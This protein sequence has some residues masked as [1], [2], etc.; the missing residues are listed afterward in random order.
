MADTDT[1]LIH[2]VTDGGI[3]G[4]HPEDEPVTVLA[5]PSPGKEFN[6]VKAFLTPTGC[7]RVEDLL[8]EF[9]SS[10]VR[11]NAREELPTLFQLMEDHSFKDLDS[12][13]TRSPVLSIF[14]HADPTGKDDYNKA[15][16]GR[17]AAAIYGMLTR[18]DEIWESL[19]QNKGG[20][21][22]VAAGDKWGANALT[23]MRD[24]LGI[25]PP[26]GGTPPPEEKDPTA[27]KTLFLA[28][29][30]FCC[31]DTSGNA[32]RVDP[33]N[34]FLARNK[35]K[36][37]VGDVQGCGEFNPVLLFPAAKKPAWTERKTS[38][39]ATRRTKPT[40]V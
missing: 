29:M 39:N 2:N 11:P 24:A 1:D 3:A 34:G 38:R 14:G 18:R 35:S 27:R 8:F 21:A 40:D 33:D 32:F 25:A 16:S 31:V 19:F 17:R 20:F 6:T 5:A 12:G 23:I 22:P 37:G 7:W 9:D 4:A 15:L 28:Y 26:D 30:D 13:E 10:V 36:D